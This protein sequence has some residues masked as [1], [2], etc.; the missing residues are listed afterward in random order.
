M[1]E[2]RGNIMLPNTEIKQKFGRI[3]RDIEQAAWICEVSAMLPQSL[4]DCIKQWEQ[5]SS[6]ARHILAS[7]DD[8]RIRRCVDD[9]E[10]IGKRAELALQQT[11][12]IDSQVKVAVTNAHRELLE[13]KMQ[14]H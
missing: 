8:G 2:E 14:L 7:E 1:N 4:R 6:Q 9:M 3:E 12:G 11:R 5:Q 10:E 13:L